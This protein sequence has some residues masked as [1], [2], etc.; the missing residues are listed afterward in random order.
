[1]KIN[2]KKIKKLITQ[3]EGLIETLNNETQQSVTLLE[4]VH[5]TYKKSAQNLLHYTAFRKID[6]RNLQRK[7]GVLGLTRFGHA[8]EHILGSLLQV[9]FILYR[10]I[11]E[12]ELALGKSAL[13]IKKGRKILR[14]HSDVLFG[15][16]SK[17]RR[18]KIMVTQPTEAAYNYDMVLAMVQNGMDCA[19]VNCAHD[20]KEVWEGIIQNIRKAALALNKDVK[21]AMDLAGPKI[22]TGKIE[23]GPKVRKFSP[24]RDEL[25]AILRPAIIHIV[26]AFTRDTSPNSIVIEKD[27]YNQLTIGEELK[28][29]D[30][31]NKSRKITVVQILENS[32]VAHCNKT[33]YIDTNTVLRSKNKKIGTILVNDVYPVPQH[34]LLKQHDTLIITKAPV[35]GASAVY[36]TEGNL[37]KPAHISC[38]LP[39][40]FEAVEEGKK[41]LF[42]DG[43]IEG[44]IEKVSSDTF[45]VRITRAAENGSK[46]KAE[47]G[48]NFP[49]SNLGISGL[50]KKD[51]LDLEFVTTHADIV[52][53]SFVN[54]KQDVQ[55]L[56]TQLDR[57]N[58]INKL[59][60]VLKIE[61]RIAFDNLVEI[62]LEAMRVEH[63]GVMIARGDLAVETGWEMIGKVQQEILSICSAAHIPV[64][65]AT[66]VLENLAKTGLP[67]RSEITDAVTSL[68]A[69][70]VMLNKGP[71]IQE[72]VRL[73]NT[74]LSDMER[75]QDKSQTMLPKMEKILKTK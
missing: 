4:N 10:I 28:G 13:S 73:L 75:F 69:E 34:L 1:M 74:L 20:N 27:D 7:L 55:E 65:W 70:C 22:R 46:L 18:V 24:K 35:L 43:K 61:T 39:Q 51:I 14:E 71:Y 45:E 50:T 40:I 42:D 37:E 47:K 15:V 5:P 56:L 68:R 25:G 52:N 30:S 41:I 60:I 2:I 9:R 57:L 49:D 62:L 67:S 36:T 6:E 29:K 53:F 11:N 17:T 31:R 26:T 12:S 21:I 32:I 16:R 33:M 59:D 66:Q 44:I 19:R 38:Q 23:P 8:E 63:I 48:I 3:I 72:A 54:S 64:V 58:A